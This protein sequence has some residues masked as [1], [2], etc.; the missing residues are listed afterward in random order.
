MNAAQRFAVS[1]F[2][3]LRDFWAVLYS[4]LLQWKNEYSPETEMRRDQWNVANLTFYSGPCAIKG[5]SQGSVPF[6]GVV[7]GD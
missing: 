5:Q 4:S 3:E 1:Y 6:I 2:E 7:A